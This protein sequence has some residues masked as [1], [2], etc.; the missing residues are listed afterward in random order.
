MITTELK[1]IEINSNS[2]S[3]SNSFKFGSKKSEKVVGD[4]KL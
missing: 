1:F 2:N 4:K 3:N